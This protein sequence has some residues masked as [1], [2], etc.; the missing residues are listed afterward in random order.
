MG[1]DMYLTKR[2]YVKRWSHQSKEEKCY[3][4]VRRNGKKL[5]YVNA[6]K[7]TYLVESV[8][9][10]RKSN[11]IHDWFVKNVQ[12]GV[13]ECQETWVDPSKLQELLDTCKQVLAASTL[14]KGKQING[15]GFD[16]HGEKDPNFIDG[17][18][19]ED[20]TVAEALLPT[21]SG[22]FFGGTEYDKWYLDDIK[23]T[24]EMLEAEL[25]IDYGRDQPEYYYRSSW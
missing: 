23:N 7:I 6:S 22:F 9:Y 21:S 11:Q 3:V 4:S 20:S 13:D 15:Y 18:V 1:L 24:I 2:H 5:P 10:W 16:E 12:N 25:A 17:E 8:A 14:V 19:I